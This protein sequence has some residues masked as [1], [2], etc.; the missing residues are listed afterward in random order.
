MKHYYFTQKKFNF[1]NRLKN[2]SIKLETVHKKITILFLA[3]I[4]TNFASAAGISV[5]SATP[6][7][8]CAATTTSVTIAYT[9]TGS[10]SAGNVFTAQLSNSSGS[11]ASPTL[12]GSVTATGSGS[13]SAII[14]SGLTAGTGYLIRVVGSTPSTTSSNSVSYT[15]IAAV[16]P[17]ISIALTSGSNPTCSGSSL[18]FTATP[19]NGGTTPSYQWKVAGTNAGTNSATFTTSSI[20]DAQTVTC[21]LTSNASC[22]T[23]ATATSSGI[24][25]TVTATPSTPTP[26]SNS[27]VCSTSTLSLSTANVSGASYSWTGPNGFTS[28]TRN[29]NITNSTT[30][31]TGT[32]SVTVTKN[33][34]TSPAGTVAAIVNQTVV[35]STSISLTSGTNPTCAGS[36]LSF[37]ASPVNGGTTPSYQWSVGGVNAGTN[38][39]T[40]TTSSITNG[41][42]VACVMTSN[43]TCA[44]PLT[45]T[46]NSISITVNAPV[47]PS[48][49]IAQTSG[50]NPMCAGT[51]A[52]FTASPVNGGTTP[53]YQWKINGTNSGTNSSTFT[54]SSLTNGQSVTCELTSNATC[55]SPAIVTSN[56]INMTVNSIVT[57]SVTIAITS[58]SNPSCSGSSVTFTA[59]AVNGG[60]T[61]A[62]QWQING[63]DAGTN[64][65]NFS[66]SALSDG[67]IVTTI[68][69]SNASCISQSSATSNSISMGINSPPT[70][71]ANATQT[72]VCAG[73]SITLTGSGAT[74]Y[75]WSHGVSD[76]VA[77]VPSSTQTYTV[78]G[79]ANGC[80]NTAQTTVVVNACAGATKLT[81]AYCGATGIALS[82]YIY[83]DAV[84]NATDYEFTLTNSSLGYSQSRIR[85]TYSAINL[86]TFSGLMYAQTYD[87]A[88]RAKVGGVWGPTGISCQITTMPFPSTQ[89]NSTSC[90]ATGLSLSSY[91]YCDAI[92]G[93]S[94]YEFTITNSGLGYSQVK[95]RTTYS[96]IGL[97]TF[98]GLAYGQT[99]NVTVRA[100]V[101]GVFSPLGAS[102]QITLMPFP[103]PQL[104]S[105]SC[106]ATGL[107]PTSYIYSESVSGA[108]D[109]EFTI[110][111]SSLGY[112]QVRTRATYSSIGL[113]MFSGLLYGQTYNVAVRAK[114]DGVYGPSGAV[115]QIT[116]MPFPATQLNS[117]SCGAAGLTLSSYIYCD[118]VAGAS[119]YEFTIT[120]TALA[121]SQA[122]IRVTYAAINLNAFTGLISG[123]TYNVTV[124]AKVSGVWGPSGAI[125][126]ISLGAAAITSSEQAL[127]TSD[128][129]S[130]NEELIS[131]E[132]IHNVKIYPNPISV[133]SVLTV[134]VQKDQA[135]KL[136]IFDVMGRIIFEKEL[137]SET[138]ITIGLSELNLDAG[139]Y[140]LSLIGETDTSNHKIMI[141]K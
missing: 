11:F 88:V 3:L 56:S 72:S 53:S 82:S 5:T 41:Q 112:S 52:T 13:I 30:A 27:P 121:Y 74:S 21:V 42:N 35:P 77:F 126:P 55:A 62:Y 87:V 132:L 20:T 84:A 29:S 49:S 114:V 93:T 10:F 68:L 99:Y 133:S 24:T 44:S 33:G 130:L 119:D 17:A 134:E 12:I 50:A 94:D 75:S 125:C 106:G 86:N 128:E 108:S 31:A 89:L 4:I 136:L 96:A 118:A 37:T 40:F 51:S 67:D 95:T 120:N 104:N 39:P 58:G 98:T 25:M 76:G 1:N 38:S 23:S 122:K 139:L 79:T 109:Y 36:S 8:G 85:V 19:T 124:K 59:S 103:G 102:C 100:K 65:S 80:S 64:S 97:N 22:L 61:P 7:S 110:T 141:T 69:S 131:N 127:R 6:S 46:S 92:A 71:V 63:S 81:N 123:Q 15:V 135:K 105:A 90:G 73:T 57:P 2:L 129:T 14:P 101:G 140:N 116:L 107:S 66:S 28:S 32:Y 54:T 48:V 43:A 117:S 138:T 78:T 26:T 45:A 60:S 34:C 16:T 115:C 137:N 83:C 9:K 70:V 111:N 18:T 47:T 113:N 91:I